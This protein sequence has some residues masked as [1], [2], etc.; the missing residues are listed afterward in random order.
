MGFF[1]WI[2]IGGVAGLIANKIMNED[3]SLIKNI[4]LGIFGG[5]VGGLTVNLIGGEGIT[6][7]N[8]W[9]LAVATLGAVIIIYVGKVISGKK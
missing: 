2:I 7:F 3:G 9:S 5:M 6:G 1:G 4:I 8:I